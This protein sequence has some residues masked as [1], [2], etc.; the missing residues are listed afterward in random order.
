[1]LASVQGTLKFTTESLDNK[2]LRSKERAAWRDQCNAISS[3][4]DSTKMFKILSKDP[5]QTVGSL[6]LPSGEYTAS[7]EA[8]F[9]QALPKL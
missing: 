8:P 4:H 7:L 3:I 1:M 2:N 9:E 6:R 5:A